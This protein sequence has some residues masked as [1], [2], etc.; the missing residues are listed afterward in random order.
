M[1]AATI[2]GDKTQGLRDYAIAQFKSGRTPILVAT[3]VAA[4]GLDIP[5]VTAVVNFDFPNVAEM[6]IHRWVRAGEGR[7]AR[8]G[9]WGGALVRGAT[10]VEAAVGSEV[11]YLGHLGGSGQDVG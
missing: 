9:G 2:H 11:W 7:W 6:Y 5:N 10:R 1:R 4:R 8:V 3:D